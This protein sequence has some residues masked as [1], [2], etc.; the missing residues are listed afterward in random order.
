MNL[1]QNKILKSE[2]HK[3]AIENIF[4]VL[5]DIIVGF[6]YDCTPEQLVA[7]R[8]YNQL[9]KSFN[10]ISYQP[11]NKIWLKS[12]LI[13]QLSTN[14]EKYSTC[15][16]FSMFSSSNCIAIDFDL[17]HIQDDNSIL[18]QQTDPDEGYSVATQIEKILGKPVFIEFKNTGNFHAFYKFDKSINVYQKKIIENY[19]QKK[20]H[21]K[22]E[23]HNKKKSVFR[24]PD[25]Y[26]YQPVN[27]DNY[28]QSYS[29]NEWVGYAY[30]YMDINVKSADD[31]LKSVG[32]TEPKTNDYYVLFGKDRETTSYFLDDFAFDSGSRND[33]FFIKGL[34]F[35]MYQ[36]C[37]CDVDSLK[38]YILSHKGSSSE[39]NGKNAERIAESMASWVEKNYDADKLNTGF[40]ASK[41]SDKLFT[42]HLNVLTEKDKKNI[43]EL[44]R[45]IKKD[46]TFPKYKK[47]RIATE[48]IDMYILTWILT[49]LDYQNKEIIPIKQIN[50]N[51]PLRK[52]TKDILKNSIAIYQEQLIQGLKAT[53]PDVNV[54]FS[55]R[56][57]MIIK[58]LENHNIITLTLKAM[59]V[60]CCSYKNQYSTVCDSIINSLKSII[61][62]IGKLIARTIKDKMELVLNN[63][64][65]KKTL[66]NMHATFD[67]ETILSN[68]DIDAIEELADEVDAYFEQKTYNRPDFNDIKTKADA[69]KLKFRIS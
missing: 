27:P 51:A 55:N 22:I 26:S 54:K 57:R 64:E 12:A 65:S 42:E 60:G 2:N 16:G 59:S 28:Y 67:S 40:K 19:L 21:S 18:K 34:G 58:Q 50:K 24:L 9:D 66:Y 6:G 20:I 37:N 52:E 48:Q 39:L 46:L 53:F 15:Y 69:L 43:N 68:N 32:Y 47:N 11:E 62:N 5:K 14:H 23:I 41:A 10:W 4:P 7:K 8:E 25:S 56:I 36:Y 31:L 30:E 33:D 63:K 38:D 29:L 49:H 44:Y 17:D 3:Q 1:I 35:L 61:M 13:K 45:I